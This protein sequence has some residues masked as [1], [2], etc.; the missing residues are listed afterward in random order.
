[1][2]PCPSSEQ[3][4]AFLDDEVSDSRRAEMQEHLRICPM[5]AAE[6]EQIKS[7][8]LVVSESPA[9]RLSQISL[10][11]LHVRVN[12]AMDRG[13]LRFVRV[14]NAVA[15]CVLVAGSAWLMVKTH[16]VRT[17]ES[18]TPAAPPWVDVAEVS[19][20]PT[21][22]YSTPAAAWYLADDRGDEVP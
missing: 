15:A 14:F 16:E 5:C 19:D 11:R 21:G 17:V 1:M 18:T 20:T 3:L 7:L 4:S 9:P 13:L 6:I 22:A 10:H 12:E 2:T 8:S